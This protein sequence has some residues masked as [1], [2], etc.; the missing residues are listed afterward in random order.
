M[1][2]KF[3][4]STII[5]LIG[6]CI[7]K[8]IGLII[9]VLTTRTIGLDGISLLSMINP[10]YSLLMTLANFN[11]L[12]STSKRISSNAEPKKVIINSCYIMFILNLILI[13]FMLLSTR[14]I[15]NNLLKNKAT[16]YPLIACTITLP[17]ISLGYIVKGYFYGKQNVAPH[18]ISNV[19]EQLLRL[20][21]ISTILPKIIKFGNIVTI[22]VLMLIN[23]LSESFSIIILLL[24][25][26]KNKVIKK[27]QAAAYRFSG[28]AQEK[29]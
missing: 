20:F 28:A 12:V 16:Y 7:T 9:K 29:S 21:I 19:L 11:F 4:K 26:P 22:T 25:I 8:I 13:I 10:T 5:L 14:F 27:A 2:N 17:F 3:L 23:I 6:G 18:M 1:K 15:S 24:Y